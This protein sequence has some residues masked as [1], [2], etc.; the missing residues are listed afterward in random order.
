MTPCVLVYKMCLLSQR[1]QRGLIEVFTVRRICPCSAEQVFLTWK[2][3][4]ATE[5]TVDQNE[6]NKPELSLLNLNGTTFDVKV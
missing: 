1:V 2:K 4:L 3:M 6:W 5:A